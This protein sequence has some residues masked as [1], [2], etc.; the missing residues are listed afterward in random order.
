MDAYQDEQLAV[1]KAFEEM[2]SVVGRQA[3]ILNPTGEEDTKNVIRRRLFQKVDKAKVK[4]I[5][6]RYK[7][8]WTKNI[9]E[10][11]SNFNANEY[12]EKLASS[13]PF[14]PMLLEALTEKLSSLDRFQRTRGMLRLLARTVHE[15]W[16]AKPKDTFCIHTHHIPLGLDTVR[17]ELTSRLDQ[18]NYTPCLKADVTAVKN[19]NPSTAQSLDQ[20]EF[21]G[22]APLVEYTARTIFINSLAYPDN[23][24]GI[25]EPD[26]KFSVLYPGLDGGILNRARTKFIENSQ[27]LDDRPDSPLRFLANPNLEQVIRRH[28]RDFDHVNVFNLYNETIRD[29]FS[30][31][32]LFRT[33]YEPQGAHSV[34]DDGAEGV[35]YLVV[36]NPSQLTVESDQASLPDNIE[37][38]FTTKG[39]DGTPR[40]FKN[41]LLFLACAQDKVSNI[42]EKTRRMLALDR[43]NRESSDYQF[44]EHQQL[45]IKEQRQ[46]AQF[47]LATAIAD[48]YRHLY[49]PSH[50]KN[51]TFTAQLRHIVIDKF[52]SANR[53]GDGQISI[54]QALKNEGK[55]QEEGSPGDSPNFVQ[56]KVMGGRDSITTQGLKSEFKKSPNLSMLYSNSPLLAMI[57][58]GIEDG[59]FIYKLGDQ[60]WGQGDPLPNIQISEE[61]EIYKRTSAEDKKLWPRPEPL[62]IHLRLKDIRELGVY[63]ILISVSGGIP[64]YTYSSDSLEE[65]KNFG[66]T[67]Q[68]SGTCNVRPTEASNYI[69]TVTD[70]QGKS[71]QASL[72]VDPNKQVSTP[73]QPQ[74]PFVTNIPPSPK[75]QKYDAEGPLKLALEDLWK[76]VR[77]NA[78]GK[79]QRIRIRVYDKD[80]VS[81]IQQGST[82]LQNTKVEVEYNGSIST[83]AVSE[84]SVN[85]IGELSK[86]SSIRTFF[87]AQIRAL[88]GENN[89]NSA[90]LYEFNEG[91]DM[92]S[93]DPENFANSLVSYGGAD[94]FVEAEVQD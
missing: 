18:S 89:V 63:P 54:R 52:S 40:I 59:V 36:F 32:N 1:V 41:N 75:I 9:S 61:S 78:V 65:Y 19:E 13:Y 86:F 92:S 71:Q 69:L 62:E 94:V 29:I 39:T 66:P 25:S 60:V 8:V 26:L 24:R 49:Y 90:F 10:L 91:L 73:Q 12:S 22:E 55:I 30:R 5:I 28:M 76:K 42:E 88:G 57:R 7:D 20:S 27:Y 64:P 35:P 80:S 93:Q 33:I 23:A 45:K 44:P 43:L 6:S 79:I 3:T 67:T 34:A 21:P 16:E 4:E 38:I 46:T 15:L 70:S 81:K 87:E 58:K 68:T 14:H 72:Y 11:P 84:F 17:D 82:S 31:G 56:Q 53:P 74:T 51:H 2:N 77:A 83:P 50:N 85:Y 37:K 47:D 48:G